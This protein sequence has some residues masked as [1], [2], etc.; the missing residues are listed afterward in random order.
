MPKYIDRDELRRKIE[1]GDRFQLAMALNEWHFE[2]ARIPGSILVPTKQDALTKLRPE[3][4]VVVYCSDASCYSSRLCVEALER[5]GY[6]NVWHYK[7]GLRDWMDAG[8]PLEGTM[9]R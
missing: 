7:G 9:A 8:F 5:A 6:P 4:E 3:E 2:A 1:R